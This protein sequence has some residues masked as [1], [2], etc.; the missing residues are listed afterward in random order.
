MGSLIVMTTFGE[1]AKSVVTEIDGS[2]TQDN[3]DVVVARCVAEGT[4]AK[5]NP[6][7]TTEP[8]ENATEFNLT[9]VKNYDTID[10]GVAA[11]VKTLQ[12]SNYAAVRAQL[13]RGDSAQTLWNVWNSSSWGHDANTLAEVQAHRDEY[14]SREIPGSPK[15]SAT[16]SSPTSGSTEDGPAPSPVEHVSVSLPVLKQ[17]M[18]GP[19]VVVLQGLVSGSIAKDGIFGPITEQALRFTQS[20]HH[21]SATGETDAATWEA[22]IG[23]PLVPMDETN[24]PKGI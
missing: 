7:A 16:S 18:T 21:V 4:E 6:M 17:A 12:L 22:L 2:P 14:Y 20:E 8:F 15:E 23:L 11:T 9:G 5:N 10:D 13:R 3:F 24:K 19:P 1:F